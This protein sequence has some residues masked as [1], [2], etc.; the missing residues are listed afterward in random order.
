MTKRTADALISS[1][2]REAELKVK[3][4]ILK[5][6]QE[7]ETKYREKQS[8]VYN[9]ERKLKKR[10]EQIEKKEK[11][12]EIR[13]REVL[14][15]EEKLRKQTEELKAQTE[16]LKKKLEEQAQ[17]TREEARKSL[18]TSLLDEVKYE[19]AR[20]IRQI[21]EEAKQTAEA[22]VRDI[23]SQTLPRCA[24]EY[25]SEMSITSVTLPNDEIKGKIIGREGRNIRT[26]ESAT[27]V[28]LIIDD[29][30][31]TVLLSC[32][33][34]FRRE[35]ARISLERL[36]QDG[37]IHP[38]RIEETV[39]K[40]KEEMEN[41]LQ[42][43]GERASFETGVYGLHPEI[44]K[45]LG[46]LRYRTSFGQN[47]LQ[48]SLEVTFLAGSLAAELKGNI[49]LAKRAALIHDIGKSLDKEVEGT[50][51]QIGAELARKYNE[52]EAVVKAIASHH[53]EEPAETLEGIIVQTADTLSAARP[54]ARR[55]T[56]ET[57]IKRI[58]KLEEIAS[59]FKGVE[60]AYAIQAGREVRIIVSPDEIND[61]ETVVLAREIAAKIEQEMEYPGQ[62]KV[63]IIREK[64]A[65]EYAK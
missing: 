51:A 9:F 43:E 21:E 36:I 12:L 2:Q 42:Q 46:K 13:E 23:L 24:A 11:T 47:V 45:L 44:I 8:S 63:N 18:L 30:P 19:A 35:V 15:R 55:E 33:D 7:L 58:K 16:T 25:V 22:R 27:G 59:E 1:A 56:L 10:A 60:K 61:E 38:T 48:H 62:I 54:G 17:L 6:S 31:E 20:K 32:F 57:Y 65:V 39:A 41:T 50:H 40:V 26:F 5:I 52:N 3:N 28:D 49:S 37:R 53:N 34:P 64:R 4:E 14:A 29:T